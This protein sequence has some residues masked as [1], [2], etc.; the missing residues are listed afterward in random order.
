MSTIRPGDGDPRHG[1]RN[2]Y[3]NLGCRCDACTSANSDY[4]YGW[5]HSTPQRYDKERERWKISSAR[6]RRSSLSST[7]S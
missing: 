2:G 7:R 5:Y 1:S 6:R 4:M 3:N